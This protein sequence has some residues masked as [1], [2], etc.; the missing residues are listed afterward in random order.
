MS[1]TVFKAILLPW[2]KKNSYMQTW[3]LKIWACWEKTYQT[4]KAEKKE[5][6]FYAQLCFRKRWL[7]VLWAGYLESLY[8]QPPW[9]MKAKHNHA[10]FQPLLIH[11]DLTICHSTSFI[12]VQCTFWL[13][14]VHSSH[15]YVASSSQRVDCKITLGFPLKIPASFLSP[16]FWE[17]SLQILPTY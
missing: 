15:C 8:S 10:L 14:P 1:V 11:S 9:V 2:K 17:A 4:S 3:M 16:L 12:S 6:W 5:V 7:L 13:L